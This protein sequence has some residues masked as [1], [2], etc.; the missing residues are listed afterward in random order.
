MKIRGSS[1][2]VLLLIVFLNI[3]PLTGS[4]QSQSQDTENKYDFNLQKKAGST[5]TKAISN[6]SQ[7]STA[8][9]LTHEYK[10]TMEKNK[11]YECIILVA[12]LIITLLIVL[13][14]MSK[15]SSFSANSIINA[16]ALILIIFGTIFIVVLSN[17]EAQLTASIGIL[18]AIAG[19]L[20]GT[21]HK[22]DGSKDTQ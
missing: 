2:M 8:D 7:I 18:G 22:R 15:K 19:Y 1:F 12:G 17:A 10:M 16:S 20:F 21:M 13:G 4:A 3:I 11:L 9:K 14:L 6:D 5:E